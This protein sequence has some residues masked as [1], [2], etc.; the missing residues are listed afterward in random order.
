MSLY[1]PG[2]PGLCGAYFPSPLAI[3]LNLFPYLPYIYIYI[4]IALPAAT[5]YEAMRG[6]RFSLEFASSS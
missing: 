3:A 1:R 2:L 4:S 5:F 6:M